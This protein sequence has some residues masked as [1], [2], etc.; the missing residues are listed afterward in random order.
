MSN[1]AVATANGKLQLLTVPPLIPG[2]QSAWS[3]RGPCTDAPSMLRARQTVPLA[4][5]SPSHHRPIVPS[6][7]ARRRPAGRTVQTPGVGATLAYMRARDS[8]NVH[9]P[10]EQELWLSSAPK[11][12][13]YCKSSS[14]PDVY[15]FEDDHIQN[16]ARDLAPAYAMQAMSRFNSKVRVTGS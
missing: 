16:S 12:C 3:A 11:P 6:Y 1:C 7:C 4:P 8:A 14:R 5:A 9:N 10:H 13:H 2:W 15:L